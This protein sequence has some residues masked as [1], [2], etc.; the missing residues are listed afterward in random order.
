MRLLYSRQNSYT[1]ETE[2]ALSRIHFRWGKWKI[3]NNMSGCEKNPRL[4]RGS[5]CY[6]QLISSLTS[7]KL[8]SGGKKMK[9]KILYEILIF[10]KTFIVTAKNKRAKY[11][12]P[13][14]EIK[15][16]FR[17]HTQN[18]SIYPTRKPQNVFTYNHFCGIIRKIRFQSES[19]KYFSVS[20]SLDE[21]P[22]GWIRKYIQ[23]SSR[24]IIF[25]N[26]VS[27]SRIRS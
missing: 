23:S 17:L 8:F 10:E 20:L 4:I 12:R 6:W 15:F 13:S 14:N 1:I 11:T 24:E 5:L 25:M 21:N 22:C 7:H 2:D 18:F 9:M 16:Y 27:M 3:S 19:L 26:P